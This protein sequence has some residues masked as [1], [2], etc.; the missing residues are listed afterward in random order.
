MIQSRTATQKTLPRRILITA[1][2]LAL[3]TLST[4]ETEG[5]VL[6]NLIANGDFE[7]GNTG[8][9]TG[10]SD[11]PGD[12]TQQGCYAV[13]SNPSDYN[14]YAWIAPS[15][16]DH[17]TGSGLMMIA[18]GA[19]T[20]NVVAW[21]QGIQVVPNTQYSFSAWAASACLFDVSGGPTPATLQLRVNGT[22]MGSPLTLPTQPGVW[23][24]LTG[25]WFSGSA[26]SATIGL[27]D[28]NTAA[29]G[30][31][32]TL[33][34]VLVT[35]Q[36]VSPPKTHVLCVG[37]R[38]VDRITLGGDTI[39]G[40]VEAAFLGV[41][42]VKSAQILPLST[43]RG[44]SDNYNFLV[45]A[46]NEAKQMVRPG[47]T[48][49]LYMAS[50]GYYSPTDLTGDEAPVNAQFDS[51]DL[52]RRRATSG[53]EYFYLSKTGTDISDDGLLSLFSGQD[54]AS[55]NKLFIVDACFSGGFWGSTATGD[56][57][58]LTSL[59]RS[60]LIAAAQEADFGWAHWDS[61][62]GLYVHNLGSALVG[63]L[64]ALK[65]RDSISFQDLVEEVGSQASVYQGINGAI[66]GLTDLK[67]AWGIEAPA[68]VDFSSTS[69]GDFTMT[70]GIPEPATLSLLALGGLAVLMRRRK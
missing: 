25:T 10:Y 66:A 51:T 16:G 27:V 42:T 67:D 36:P 48:F 59:S 32:F 26:T 7:Q 22:G 69:T 17:T 28:L 60:A 33:D 9:T 2:I 30:N 11:E 68:V 24:N 47:D 12:W 63:A 6:A 45:A 23:A 41:K 1:G 31:D 29:N 70:L 37:V 46:I 53:D 13:G 56:S 15:F 14:N 64:D 34:D 40:R 20:P 38:D 3:A 57:G 61:S 35:P 18:A 4:L 19:T 21:Q 8:F 39:A 58:D 52:S 5:P 43:E 50:H 62:A 65:N 49:I 44:G 55:V 54:W